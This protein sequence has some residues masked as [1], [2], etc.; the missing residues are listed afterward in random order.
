MHQ[1]AAM[2]GV[3]Y[4]ASLAKS[5]CPGGT[6]AIRACRSL[7]DH[8]A[9]SKK[10]LGSCGGRPPDP[11]QVADPRMSQDQPHAGEG[12]AGLHRVTAQSRDSAPGVN[13]HGQV[14]L[15]GHGEHR[16]QGR[17][18][19]REALRAGMELD[20]ASA[21]AQAPLGL[22]EWIGLRI[23]AAEGDEHGVAG[24]GLGQDHVVGLRIAVGLVHCEHGSA[25]AG[26]PEQL[27]QLGG[28]AVVL[29]GVVRP[30]VRVGVERLRARHLLACA[31]EQGEERG[32]RQHG[33]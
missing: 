14:P 20:A 31:L 4:G 17:V 26:P 3:P 32:V 1:V 27:Q 8:H 7:G 18:I 6:S 10:R 24:R 2:V 15:V 11:G 21:R 9:V 19:E 13:E 28:G 22:G 33:R 12:L 5:T 16:P 29:V 30:Q 25:G 23:E